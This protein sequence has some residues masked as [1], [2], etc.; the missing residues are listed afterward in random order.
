MQ[1]LALLAAGDRDDAFMPAVYRYQPDATPVCEQLLGRQLLVLPQQAV[2]WVR[3]SGL[4]PPAATDGRCRPG[5]RLA[6]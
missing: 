6:V 5:A 2:D 4:M 1:L 3:L